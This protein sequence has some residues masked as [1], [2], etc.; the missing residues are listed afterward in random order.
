MTYSVAEIIDI[1]IAIEDTGYEFYC[2][3]AGKFKNE[4][5]K[6]TFHY[7]AA[8]ELNHK[9]TFESIKKHVPETSGNFTEE[10]Y[11]YLKSIGSG[12]IFR[13]NIKITE[14]VNNIKTPHEAL[15]KAFQDEK[16]S[17]LYYSEVQKLYDEKSEASKILEK[18]ILEERQH[19]MK[20]IALYESL[21]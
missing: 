13:S 15:E 12:K 2:A 20:L 21:Q 10:Y 4:L 8:E 3:C 11:L 6:K 7:L 19:T 14:I 17:I 18:I 16:D 1:A 9:K 5:I